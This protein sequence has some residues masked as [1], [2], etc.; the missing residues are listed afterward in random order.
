[1]WR[2]YNTWIMYYLLSFLV[3]PLVM[4]KKK[5]PKHQSCKINWLYRCMKMSLKSLTS[6]G[7][8]MKR[9]S[10]TL[11]VATFAVTWMTWNLRLM[12]GKHSKP[13]LGEPWGAGCAWGGVYWNSPNIPG[14][15]WGPMG[16][17]GG[18]FRPNWPGKNF[19]ECLGVLSTHSRFN[20]A[21]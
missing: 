6:S 9:P 14:N 7:S 21:L 12:A 8:Q 19:T 1:M 16:V 3:W 11:P 2:M 15:K 5:K 10:L 13:S 17:R 18:R 4:K 20:G